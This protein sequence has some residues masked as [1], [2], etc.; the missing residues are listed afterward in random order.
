MKTASPPHS[1]KK[2]DIV[3]K[4]TKK[5]I[6]GNISSEPMQSRKE[7]NYIFKGLKEKHCQLRIL[8]SVQMS[9]KSKEETKTFL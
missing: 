1:P 5:R 2:E 7:Y 3:Y 4:G 8:Y 9:S 6:T